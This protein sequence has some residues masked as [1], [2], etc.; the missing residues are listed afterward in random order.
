[1][2]CVVFNQAPILAQRHFAHT[3]LECGAN[4]VTHTS[5][6]LI[7]V[8]LWPVRLHLSKVGA[9]AAFLPELFLLEKPAM[10][11]SIRANV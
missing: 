2:L 8:S 11:W 5:F 9:S 1:M 3:A 10:S 7:L 4:A 6:F